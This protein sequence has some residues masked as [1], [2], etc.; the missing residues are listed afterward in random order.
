[1]T[2]SENRPKLLIWMLSIWMILQIPRFVA[3]PL[4]IDVLN[5]IDSPAWMYPA[6]LDV[7]IALPSPFLAH[8]VWKRRGLGVWAISVIYLVVS[9][10]DHGDAAVAAMLTG[11]P[12]VFQNMGNGPATYIVPIVQAIFDIAFLFW[13]TRPSVRN[14]FLCAGDLR[15]SA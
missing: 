11:T 12:R 7:V 9:I 8:A 3:V 4:I 6:I 1:M 14:Y 5:G 15:R 13:I 2:L 10:I